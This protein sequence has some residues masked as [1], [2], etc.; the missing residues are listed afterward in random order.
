MKPLKVLISGGGT[1][2]HIFP[3]V[4]IANEIKRRFPNSIIEF[5]GARGRMEMEKVPMEGYRIHGLWISGLQ[6]KMD[7]V[8]LLLPFKVLSSLWRSLVL[9]RRFKPQLTVG[10]GGYASGPLNF[11]ASSLGISL[12]LQEQNSYPGITNKLLK[13]KARA[14]CVAYP[15]MERYF[16]Q[17]R[18]TITGNPIRQDILEYNGSREDA[19]RAF[20]LDSNR[21]TILI[22]GGSLGARSINNAIRSSLA[23][24][25]ADLQLLWQTGKSFEEEEGAFDWGVRRVF[26]REMAAAYR[27]ADVVISRAGALSIS[28]LA[29]LGKAAIFVPLPS[30]AEDHQT[31]NALSLVQADAALICPDADAGEKLLPMAVDLINNEPGRA[32]L[33]QRIREFGKPDAARHIVDQIA[34]WFE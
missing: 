4:A 17:D 34:G 6:R 1:G 14:I 24:L 19:C 7:P 8:N 23:S 3:A 18:I 21:R 9:V 28:E 25:P 11:V 33:E 30:A 13:N 15:G 32:Q 22:V 10:V 31:R 12:L 29:A 16:P 5:V 27:A 2:G 26:I 20:G